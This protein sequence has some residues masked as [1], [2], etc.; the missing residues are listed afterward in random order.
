MHGAM[1][2]PQYGPLPQMPQFNPRAPEFHPHVS[3]HP[4]ALIGGM[5]LGSSS[6]SYPSGEMKV[7]STPTRKHRP[8]TSS[9]SQSTGPRGRQHVESARGKARGRQYSREN[10]SPPLSRRTTP[11]RRKRPVSY[12]DV[13]EDEEVTRSDDDSSSDAFQASGSEEEEEY[14]IK[15]E[16]DE[17]GVS[18]KKDHR[19]GSSHRRTPRSTQKRRRP[20]HTEEKRPASKCQSLHS[21]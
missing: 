18:P 6:P 20:G 13:A 3:M 21:K 4:H 14:I 7:P 17:E 5:H 19:R 9:S 2:V 1:Y 15:Y 12:K 11:A 10:G 16:S 8:T